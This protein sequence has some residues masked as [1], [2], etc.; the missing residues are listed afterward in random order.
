MPDA[1]P[2]LLL[3]AVEAAKAMSVCPK[4]LWSMTQPRGPIPC[5]R[6]RSRVLYPLDGLKE[7]IASQAGRDGGGANGL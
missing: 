3:S 7:W 4:T 6:C 5:V 2:K 1:T